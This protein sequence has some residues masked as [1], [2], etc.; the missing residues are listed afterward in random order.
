MVTGAHLMLC[1]VVGSTLVAGCAAWK[2]EP[3]EKRRELPTARMSPD[4]VGLDY[5]F[6]R[7]PVDQVTAVNAMW[8]E[9]DETRISPERRQLL[10]RNGMRCAIVGEQLPDSIRQLLDH[11]TTADDPYA[12]I[13]FEIDSDG[14][15]E[16][17]SEKSFRHLNSR[18]G[19][20]NHIVATDVLPQLDVITHRQGLLAG[21][22]FRDAQCIFLLKSFP[23][24][25]GRVR[26]EL[27]PEIHHGA[28]QRDM[29]ADMGIWRFDMSRKREVYESLRVEAMLSPGESLL[30]A[31]A[32][33]DR[34][35]GKNFLVP[36]VKKTSW[37]RKMLIV[38]LAQTQH[39]A[40][41]S[42]EADALPPAPRVRSK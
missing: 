3:V 22:T 42:A 15:K 25:D 40:L 41:F 28:P 39:D 34:G 24:G 36:H 16:R 38:R 14:R 32:P 23:L 2:K 13:A 12:E 17:A 7:V 27:T 18:S 20:P 5:G 4:S 29:V 19:Q 26:L 21:R 6:I 9:L 10:L 37:K 11:P 35:L 8:R 1:V 33:N 30:V 31:P